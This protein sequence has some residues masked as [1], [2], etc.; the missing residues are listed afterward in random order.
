M[1]LLH[2]FRQDI[3]GIEPPLRFNNPFYYLPHRLC[4]IA[5][6][7]LRA[8]LLADEAAA[9]DAAKIFIEQSGYTLYKEQPFTAF[10]P[11]SIVEEGY[12]GEEQILIQGIIDLLAVKEEE[13]IIIDYKH[14]S[15]VSE[16]ALINRYKKQLEL[17]AYAVEKVLKKDS[18]WFFVHK[19]IKG[20][21][22]NVPSVPALE[23]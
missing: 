1:Q 12:Q 5:A 8:F 4:V 18:G 20:R 13:A 21:A 10:I 17:Y 16:G 14:S 19:L 11:A 6:D 15:T 22:I 23:V 7:E 2:R 3:T 9:A